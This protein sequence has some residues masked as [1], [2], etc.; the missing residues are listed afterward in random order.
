MCFRS[1]DGSHIGVPGAH[2]AVRRGESSMWCLPS[3]GSSRPSNRKHLS[4]CEQ[5]SFPIAPPTLASAATAVHRRKPASDSVE[6]PAPNSVHGAVALRV[7]AFTKAMVGEVTVNTA[8]GGA[9]VPDLLCPMMVVQ[10]RLHRAS[11]SALTERGPGAVSAAPHPPSFSHVSTAVLHRPCAMLKGSLTMRVV[12]M[13]TVAA[14]LV[15]TRAAVERLWLAI[16]KVAMTSSTSCR[17]LP[18]AGWLHRH[19]RHVR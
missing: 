17:P 3:Y 2:G 12:N 1:I 15:Q 13:E 18:R 4:F 7:Y 16:G 19:F 11:V 5:N 14:P 8:D 6:Y 10:H 9:C